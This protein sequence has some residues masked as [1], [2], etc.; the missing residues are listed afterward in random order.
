MRTFCLL[1]GVVGRGVVGAGVVI[2]GPLMH[3]LTLISTSS[4]TSPVLHE[5]LIR[6]L[7]ITLSLDGRAICCVP[8]LEKY[9]GAYKKEDTS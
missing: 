3:P 5:S 8:G 7:L 6:I 2:A 4:H 9:T 1:P